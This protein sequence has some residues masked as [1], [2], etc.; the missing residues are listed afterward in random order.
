MRSFGL[1]GGHS[2][3]IPSPWPDTILF[4]SSAMLKLRFFLSRS[5]CSGGI[6]AAA[7]DAYS[8]ERAKNRPAENQ[9]MLAFGD[10][11]RPVFAERRWRIA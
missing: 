3:G 4:M 1:I 7:N 8:G 10:V 5:A 9:Y 6:I 11:H 2:L